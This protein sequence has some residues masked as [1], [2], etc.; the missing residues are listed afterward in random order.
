MA[1]IVREFD[2]AAPADFVWQAIRD[3]GAPHTRLA[4]GFVVDTQLEAG[5][6]VVTFANGLT[7]RELIVDVSDERRRFAYSIVA[8]R[9]THHNASFE[10]HAAGN[11][12]RVRWVTDVLPHELGEPF[13]RM[14][15][16]GVAAMKQTVESDFAAGPF[17][18]VAAPGG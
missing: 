16:A 7:A 9:A 10:V 5:A 8:G 6:R 13:A 1:S 11:K 3:L 12:S 2:V 18:A 15:D 4:R 14:V 17:A